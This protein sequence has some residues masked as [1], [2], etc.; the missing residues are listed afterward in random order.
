MRFTVEDSDS[1]SDSNNHEAGEF[2]SEQ[3]KFDRIRS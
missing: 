3:L 2:D 1:N